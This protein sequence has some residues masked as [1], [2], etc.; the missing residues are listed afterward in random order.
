[1][2]EFFQE[3]LLPLDS[4][5]KK[6]LLVL[7]FL[8]LASMVLVTAGVGAVLPIMVL[9]VEEDIY[10]KYPFLVP[11]LGYL[12][13]PD[14]STLLLIAVAVFF[15]VIALKVVTAFLILIKQKQLTAEIRIAVSDRL[16]RHILSLPLSFHKGENSAKIVRN[17]T[18][19][20][21][22]HGRCLESSV[23]ILSEGLVLIALIS[24]LAIVDPLGLSIVSIIVGL[25]GAG[26][27]RIIQPKITQWGSKFRE[28]AA[29]MVQHT[30]QALGGIKEIKVLNREN[31]FSDLFRRS[32]ND[33]THYERK[34]SVVQAIPVNALELLIA[35]SIF[36]LV[37]GGIIRGVEIDQ[38]LPA[39]VLF[40]ASAIRLGPSLARV[41]GAFQ[42]LRYNRPAM[43][44]LYERLRKDGDVVFE[45]PKTGVLMGVAKNWGKLEMS[46]LNFSYD[47]RE[48]FALEK[49]NLTIH[50][51][52][53][54]G[55][56]GESGSG[57]STLLDI[58]LGL[59]ENYDGR[60]A[61]DGVDLRHYRREWQAGIG[62][63]PQSVYL[64]DDSVKRNI[65]LGITPEDVNEELLENA[66]EKAQLSRFVATLEHGVDSIVGERGA[67]ISGGQ[68]QRIGIARALYR[69][70][71]VLI[72]D[73]ATSALDS[74][75]ENEFM[76]TVVAM[77]GTITM[78]IV[79]HR[80]STLRRCDRLIRLRNG[81]I[82]G[83]GTYQDLI[84]DA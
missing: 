33:M 68:Q 19:D 9:V 35:T 45:I 14:R 73:E 23:V 71:T 1:M 8:A 30:Q 24:L 16:F 29:L 74:E 50:K 58:I 63:V 40:V 18:S 22:G 66:I 4:N 62:Y 6:S 26:Y 25:I 49:I 38:F 53:A 17:L 27:F 54:I 78:V 36:L 43:Q 52:E 32:V 48:E 64:L 70:P 31:F 65:A 21:S 83:E 57:K 39:L 72:L 5:Q 47:D 3:L 51:G 20:I 10:G 44:A 84:H 15:I 11:L 59:N 12:G 7:F 61:L 2:K 82:I 80:V 77:Q 75:T 37:L 41:A 60:I 28:E 34:Y 76:E 79:A 46:D 67:R 13:N 42:T 69:S 56:V 81:Q 55:I